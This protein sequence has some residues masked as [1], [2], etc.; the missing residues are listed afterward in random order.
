MKSQKLLGGLLAMTSL[1]GAFSSLDTGP[2]IPGTG[3]YGNAPK[4]AKT[5]RRRAAN[6][7]ARAERKRQRIYIRNLYAQQL[8][9]TK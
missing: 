6:K 7:R 2:H 1:A 8:S 4:D 5:R 3:G 9:E